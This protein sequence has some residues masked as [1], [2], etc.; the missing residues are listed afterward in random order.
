M[1]NRIPDTDHHEPS[2]EDISALAYK[3]WE[4]EGHPNG[5]AAEHW[6]DATGQLRAKRLAELNRVA[7]MENK[8]RNSNR[9]PVLRGTIGD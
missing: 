5:R 8:I 3:I 4:R 6:N 2:R 1:K 9:L 7:R